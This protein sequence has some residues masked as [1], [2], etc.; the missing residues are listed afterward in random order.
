MDYKFHKPKS[1]VDALDGC[2][3]DPKSALYGLCPPSPGTEKKDDA[4]SMGERGDKK[5]QTSLKTLVLSAM[6]RTCT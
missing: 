6:G 3:P 5:L 4:V 1:S 2:L